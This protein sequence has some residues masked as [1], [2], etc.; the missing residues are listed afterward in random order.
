LTRGCRPAGTSG[1]YGAT[2]RPIPSPQSF[3]PFFRVKPPES[4]VDP[5]FPRKTKMTSPSFVVA[6][7]KAAIESKAFVERPSPPA[8]LFPSTTSRT[9]QTRWPTVTFTVPLVAPIPSL[10][11]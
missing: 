2:V 6:A 4:A 3:W 5:V 8:A 9:Y 11:W 1:P 7:L 10:T